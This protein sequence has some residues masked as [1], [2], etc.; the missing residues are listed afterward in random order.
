M[1][2]SLA[3]LQEEIYDNL[4]MDQNDISLTKVNQ[5][6]NRAFWE[7][8]KKLKFRQQ[9]SEFVI[10]LTPGINTYSFASYVSDLD[11]VRHITI[12]DTQVNS[13]TWNTIIQTDYENLMDAEDDTIP[14]TTIPTKYARFDDKIVFNYLPAYGYQ[15]KVWYKKSLGD[16]LTTGP[17]IPEEWHELIAYRATAR[18]WINKGSIPKA[19]QMFAVSDNILRDLIETETK[20]EKD[21]S[22]SSA[23]ILR[24]RYP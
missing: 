10:V 12:L 11:A 15:V 17:S 23:R 16:V 21:Y 18:C 19:T 8:S 3:N 5:N 22:M 4:G 7:I 6:I 20:E 9:D 14:P 13:T 1:S 2:L 24:A